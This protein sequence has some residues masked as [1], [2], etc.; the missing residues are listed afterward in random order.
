[1][2]EIIF[3][4]ETTGFDPFSGD[5]VIEIGAVEMVNRVLTGENFHAYCNPERD[6][7]EGAVKIHG[8]TAEFLS[9]KPLIIDVLD[10]F[11]AFVGDA[12]LVA[13]NATFDMKFINWE[14]EN[15][16][17]APIPKEQFKDTLVIARTKYPGQPNSLDALCKRL[18]VN[19]SNRALHGALLDSEILADVYVEL[20]GGRQAGL[21]LSVVSKGMTGAALGNSKKRQARAFVASD[22]EKAAHTAFVDTLKEPIWKR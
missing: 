1:M 7:P 10:D 4:T 5:R 12:P 19:N 3:D 15:A 2:R 18:G 22:E 6:I 16:S 14:L 21:D 8:I 20:L 13:H 17:K 11:I 9:D